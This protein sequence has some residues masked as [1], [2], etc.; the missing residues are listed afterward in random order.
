MLSFHWW[1]HFRLYQV[2]NKNP[3]MAE[4]TGMGSVTC[5]LLLS[6]TKSPGTAT[7]PLHSHFQS[8]S[9]TKYRIFASLSDRPRAIVTLRGKIRDLF[10]WFVC[11]VLDFIFFFNKRI[12]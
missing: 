4:V 6:P 5:H 10:C 8:S 9:S 1:S 12:E 7:S 3:E 11:F 2:P